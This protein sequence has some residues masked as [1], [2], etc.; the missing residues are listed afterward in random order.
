MSRRS[1]GWLFASLLIAGCATS[2]KGGA[3]FDAETNRWSGRLALNVA[4]EPPQ[5]FSAGF[6]LSGQPDKGE[7]RLTSPLGNILG[8]M[9]WQ[10]GQAL[11]SQG[12]QVRQFDSVEALA[13]E[14]TGA[15]IPV[16]AL[17]AWLRGQP[18]EVT[19]WQA[20]LGQLPAG[21][22]SAQRQMPL[23]TAELRIVLDR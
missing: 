19:G 11:L 20:D 23:P 6:E 14:V 10:P 8:V 2:T 12:E 18:E 22:L 3:S 17:F 13:A 15:P 21:R 16:R 7:L 1:V 4:S 5:S 9:Q